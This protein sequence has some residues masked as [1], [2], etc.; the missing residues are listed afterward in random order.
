MHLPCP[1]SYPHRR[2]EPSKCL[3]RFGHSTAFLQMG[4]ELHHLLPKSMSVATISAHVRGPDA[5]GG[6]DGSGGGLGG[7]ELSAGSREQ[8]SAPH[9]SHQHCFRTRPG[10]KEKVGQATALRHREC[11]LHN[12]PIGMGVSDEHGAP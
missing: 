6:G 8:L 2:G 10:T 1:A 9:C 7:G 4:S 3:Y 5:A 12:S 11:W